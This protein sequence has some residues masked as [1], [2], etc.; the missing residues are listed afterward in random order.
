MTGRTHD[1][2]AALRYFDK[3]PPNGRAAVRIYRG[4]DV[5]RYL[6]SRVYD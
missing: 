3:K 5:K 1:L 6:D 4:N 2:S